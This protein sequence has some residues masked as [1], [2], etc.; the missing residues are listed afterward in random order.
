MQLSRATSGSGRLTNRLILH[1]KAPPDLREPK[2]SQDLREIL[3]SGFDEFAEWVNPVAAS[4]ARLS[5]EPVQL[6]RVLDGSALA[7]ADGRTYQDFLSGYGT[8]A[9]GHRNPRVAAAL[10]AFLDSDAPS[11]F[12]SGVSPFAGRLARQL[13]ERTGYGSISLASSGTEAI[14]AALKMARAATGRGRILGLAGAYHGCTLG[15]L[16]LMAQGPFRDPFGPHLQGVEALPFGDVKALAQALA[17]DDV[18]AVVVEP[19]QVEGGVRILPADYVA[20]LAELC[21]RHGALVIAD[22]VQTGLCRTGPFLASHSWPRRPDLVV[23]AKALGGGL[24]PL[25]AT[26]AQRDLFRSAYGTFA[27]AESH[28][29]TFAGNALSC[30]AGLE[31]LAILT[32]DLASHV[33]EVGAQFQHALRSALAELPL[34]E[35]VRG[36]GLLVGVCFK[37]ADHPWLDFDAL[38]LPELAGKPSIGLLLCH[39]LFRRGYLVHVAG[40]N[41]RVMRLQP[42]LDISAERLC[43][44]VTACREEVE[45]LCQLL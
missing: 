8:Q 39:R 37:D 5:G 33:A 13:G 29:Y 31:S 25:S 35:T 32:E 24:V 38:G 23:I 1:A 45:G 20:A 43:A 28:H 42:P 3:R 4:R 27:S 6:L 41:W 22:E 34:V 16:A 18:A 9:L 19:I 14:E 7:D 36:A 17:Q 26:L 10:R 12:T 15:S 2:D 11:F 40:H 44:F 21:P 30:V